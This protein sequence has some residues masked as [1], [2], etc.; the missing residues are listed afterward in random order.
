MW[1]YE[2]PGVDGKGKPTRVIQLKGRP[3]PAE[4]VDGKNISI[5]KNGKGV[6][7]PTVRVRYHGPKGSNPADI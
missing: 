4:Q 5:P 3:L 1:Q 2:V 7:V 6:E